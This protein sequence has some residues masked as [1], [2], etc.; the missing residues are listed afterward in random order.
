MEFYNMQTLPKRSYD[1]VGN[2]EDFSV[3]V[4]VFSEDEPTHAELGFYNFDTEAWSHFG[5]F[6]MMLICW[7]YLPDPTE[8]LKDKDFVAI[9]HEGYLP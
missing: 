2:P 6:S 5:D 7:C 9:E 8:F 3:T 1:L 4:L